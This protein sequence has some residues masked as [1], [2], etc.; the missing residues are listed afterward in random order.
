[1]WNN[2]D[3]E[4]SDLGLNRTEDPQNLAL[5]LAVTFLSSS[6][7]GQ[8]LPTTPSQPGAHNRIL[9]TSVQG[10]KANRTSLATPQ[11]QPDNQC[12]L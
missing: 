8:G 5:F 10:T 1:M 12:E 3:P 6:P 9:A 4:D 2:G 7:T 11:H